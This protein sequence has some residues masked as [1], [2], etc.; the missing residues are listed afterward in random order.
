MSEREREIKGKKGSFLMVGNENL[1]VPEV[2]SRLLAN[3]RHNIE[4]IVMQYLNCDQ[5]GQ[6]F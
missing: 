1:S 4:N 3:I 6:E 2:V 5:F